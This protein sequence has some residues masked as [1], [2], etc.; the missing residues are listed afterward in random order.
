MLTAGVASVDDG[1]R[2]Q[3]QACLE[4]TGLAQTIA[5]WNLAP[6][7]HPQMA[8]AVPDVVLLEL[9]RDADVPLEFAAHLYRLRPSVCIIACSSAQQ[10]SPDLLMRAMRS[11]V[12]EF[13]PQPVDPALLRVTLER[14]I[15]E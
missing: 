12:R 4:Q 11:G 10:P 15:K 8:A 14:L 7:Q 6:E 2:T 9:M 3:L 1:S 13:L 5:A